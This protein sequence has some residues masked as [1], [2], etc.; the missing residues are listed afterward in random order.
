MRQQRAIVT[1]STKLANS[2]PAQRK[3]SKEFNT[4]T[5]MKFVTIENSGVRPY[6]A[7]QITLVTNQKVNKYNQPK[8]NDVL[9]SRKFK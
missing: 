1:R 9:N 2:Y 4:Y 6:T 7:Y 8:L 3:N 5:Y